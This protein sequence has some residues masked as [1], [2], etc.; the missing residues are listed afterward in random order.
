MRLRITV[1]HGLD[2]HEQGVVVAPSKGRA[3]PRSGLGHSSLQPAAFRHEGI[4]AAPG[5][6]PAGVDEGDTSP[7]AQCTLGRVTLGAVTL[8]P[9]LGP[10][11]WQW[12]LTSYLSRLIIECIQVL[13]KVQQQSEKE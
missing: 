4:C 10:V 13:H 9:S 1:D 8:H 11:S 7:R 2:M 6:R 3:A 12:Y 5:L